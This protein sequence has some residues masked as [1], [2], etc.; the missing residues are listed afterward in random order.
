MD[1]FRRFF[2]QNK[3]KLKFY[4]FLR[5]PLIEIGEKDSLVE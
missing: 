4:P 5:K 2:I 3:K 1:Y